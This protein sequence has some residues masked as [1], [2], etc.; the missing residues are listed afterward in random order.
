MAFVLRM[1]GMR[2]KSIVCGTANV[3][4]NEIDYKQRRIVAHGPD[5]TVE[6]ERA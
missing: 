5:Q 1:A 4:G 6:R 3:R 2:K